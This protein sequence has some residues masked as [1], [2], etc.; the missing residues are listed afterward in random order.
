M[1]LKGKLHEGKSPFIDVETYKFKKKKQTLKPWISKLNLNLQEKRILM[2]PTGW[3]NDSIIDAAQKLLKIANTAIP[4]LQMN[5]RT[6]SFDIQTGEFVQVLHNGND[7]W[8][9]IST[10]GVESSAVVKVYDS[11]YSYASEELKMHIA[12]ILHS[13]LSV[14]Q[15]QFPQ[16][17]RQSGSSDC[18]LFALAFATSVVFNVKPEECF[19]EQKLMRSHLATCFE[20]GK[21]SMFPM[22]RR[23]LCRAQP[24]DLDTI[25]LHC[26]CRMP[27]FSSSKWVQCS[28]CL[29][30]FH[31]GTC[32]QVPEHCLKRD[33]VLWYCPGCD[34]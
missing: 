22:K 17:Q 26:L 21:I 32:V 15:L 30:W 33:D 5:Y 12:S 9:T 7:H 4:G 2:S 29:K 1:E 13:E 16:V 27:E 24:E 28:S 23:R 10:I 19:F 11:L 18:G 8:V 34:I 6:H 14:I 3:L 31:A 20:E 25:E